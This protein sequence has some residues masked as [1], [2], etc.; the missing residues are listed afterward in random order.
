MGGEAS[1]LEG[2]KQDVIVDADTD[3]TIGERPSQVML[4]RPDSSSQAKLGP[5]RGRVTCQDPGHLFGTSVVPPY[6]FW[7]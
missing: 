4:L 5:I 3:S 6:L 2:L 1:R 7:L